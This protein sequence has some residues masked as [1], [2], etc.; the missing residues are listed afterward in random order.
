MPRPASWLVVLCGFSL[1]FA[2]E[3]AKPEAQ[4]R[5]RG[6]VTSATDG[7][8]LAGATVEVRDWYDVVGERGVDVIAPGPR[9]VIT[10]G[11]DGTFEVPALGLEGPIVTVTAKGHASVSW[12]EDTSTSAG[13]I[14]TRDVAL[15]AS[16]PLEGKVVGPDGASLLGVRVFAVE[17]DALDLGDH[18]DPLAAAAD[19]LWGP[20]QYDEKNAFRYV[21][22]GIDTGGRFRILGADAARS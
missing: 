6:R 2:Q 8:P 4:V 17:W 18:P 11:A 12:R 15:P 1:A 9:A 3:P 19:L 10:A 20:G 14:P 21:A 7:Q 5:L 22:A 16:A 13:R